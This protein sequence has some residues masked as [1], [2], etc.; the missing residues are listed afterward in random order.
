MTA[1]NRSEAQFRMS[2]WNCPRYDRTE[3]RCQDGKANPKKKADSVA[4]AEFLGVRAL[5]HYNPYRDR[6]ALEMHYPH[7]PPPA[8][9]AF[10]RPRRRP[11][12]PQNPPEERAADAPASPTSVRDARGE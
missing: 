4:V 9:P 7:Q 2:C 8:L 5:C 1:K 10:A 6:L 12:E 3:R 11:R